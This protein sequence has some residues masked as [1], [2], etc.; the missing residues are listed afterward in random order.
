MPVEQIP[1]SAA[2]NDA[3]MAHSKAVREMFGGIAG[4]YDLLNHLLSLNVDKGWRRRVRY[5]LADV[6]SRSDAEVLDV[7]CGTGDLSIE[8]KHDANASVTGTDFC[9]PML[10][11]AQTK[12]GAE[13]IPFVEADAME[14]PFA[15]ASFDALTI[16]F[17]LRNLPNVD[18]GLAEMFRVIKPRGRL[19]VLEFSSPVVPGFRQVFNFYFA[20]VLPRIGGL[21]SGSRAAYTYLPASVAK[22]PDQ[23]KLKKKFEEVGFT[24]VRYTNLT[25]GIAAMHVGSRP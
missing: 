9:R 18:R 12:H 14:L 8:L 10:A 19:V 17:G 7:A 3:E 5:E 6:L 4:K 15:D 1:A 25:G 2:V 24:D 11:I 16:A 22:F 20:Q 13:G 23:K 21:V